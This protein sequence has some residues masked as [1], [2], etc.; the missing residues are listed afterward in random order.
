[1]NHVV[2]INAIALRVVKVSAAAGEILPAG[3]SLTTVLAF[4]ASISR[5]AQRLNAMAAERAKTIHKST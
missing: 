1:M 4:L 2:A 3:I 5:S